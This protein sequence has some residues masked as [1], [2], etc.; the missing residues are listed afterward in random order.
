MHIIL[1]LIIISLIGPVAGSL[2]GVL[3][4]PSDRFMFNMLAFAAGVM[5]AVS[6][7]QLIPEA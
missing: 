2:I 7:L 3:K 6:F 4:K 5:L 1:T